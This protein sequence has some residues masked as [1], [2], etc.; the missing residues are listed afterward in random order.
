MPGGDQPNGSQANAQLAVPLLDLVRAHGRV[1]G[2]V[3]GRTRLHVELRAV[4]RALDHAVDQRPAGERASTVR[5]PIVEMT[6]ES[7]D[8]P[9]SFRSTT[10]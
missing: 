5:A 10:A 1:S 2:A 4:P 8:T 7:P 3:H 6:Q 9:A